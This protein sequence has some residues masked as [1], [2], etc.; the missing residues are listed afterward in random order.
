MNRTIEMPFA[1]NYKEK[2][3]IYRQMIIFDQELLASKKSDLTSRLDKTIDAFTELEVKINTYCLKTYASIEQAIQTIL[4]KQNT[5][6]FFNYKI[7]NDP[8]LT[9]KNRQKDPTHKNTA[10]EYVQVY[11][12]HFRIELRLNE[13]AVEKVLSVCGC[14]PLLT[15][16]IDLPLFDAI[17]AHKN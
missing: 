13:D 4:S 6:Y 16:K 2:G 5:S 12:D 15:D 11:K 1:F 3:Y 14:Y 7:V 10:P 9:Y 17:P 8:T